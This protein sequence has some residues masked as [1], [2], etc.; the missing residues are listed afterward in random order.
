MNR[1]LKTQTICSSFINHDGELVS[2]VGQDLAARRRRR[3]KYDLQKLLQKARSSE[4]RMAKFRGNYQPAETLRD[5]PWKGRSWWR[6]KPCP[7]FGCCTELRNGDRRVRSG[8]QEDV[9]MVVLLPWSPRYVSMARLLALKYH[10]QSSS[11][12]APWGQWL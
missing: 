4:E 12:W 8:G 7:C 1:N 6:R 3:P 10:K 9:E 5:P 2:H 11:W